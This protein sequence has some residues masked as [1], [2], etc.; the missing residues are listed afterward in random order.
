MPD[1]DRPFAATP[2]SD[3]AMIRS[4]LRTT[5]S[6]VQRDLHEALFAVGSHDVGDR[7]RDDRHAGCEEFRRLRRA[8]EPRRLVHC[9]RH[10]AGVPAGKIARQLVVASPAEPVDVGS[11]RK[12]RFVDLDHRAD[13]HELPLRSERS[14]RADEV[15]V[16]ALV[17][18]AEEAE[19]RMGNGGLVIG[20]VAHRAALARNASKSIDDGKACTLRCRLRLA[21]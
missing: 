20:L 6:G 10:Q 15:D 13:H 5:S 19:P 9:E 1:A 12:R 14:K 16:H 2:P 11:A 17:D 7:R 4:T 21:S 8:D 3:A 18:H